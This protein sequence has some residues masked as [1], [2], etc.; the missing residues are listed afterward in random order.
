MISQQQIGNEVGG[1]HDVIWDTF[2]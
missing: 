1:D 2:Q